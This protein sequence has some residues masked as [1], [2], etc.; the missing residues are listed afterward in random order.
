MDHFVGKDFDNHVRPSVQA[1]FIKLF[2][3]QTKSA[4]LR[5]EAKDEV[6]EIED[7]SHDKLITSENKI[8]DIET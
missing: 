7:D 5:E 4:L 8:I 2:P 6:I 1:W 3:D